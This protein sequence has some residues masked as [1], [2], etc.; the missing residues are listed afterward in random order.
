M[1]LLGLTFASKISVIDSIK[2]ALYGAAL[3]AIL[4][5]IEFFNSE[6]LHDYI[7]NHF[8]NL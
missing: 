3:S 5:P 1:A 8:T 2:I 4:P 7:Q 6:K